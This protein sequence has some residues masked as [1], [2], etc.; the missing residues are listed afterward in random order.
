MLDVGFLAPERR[1]QGNGRRREA[2]VLA[3]EEGAQEVAVAVGGDRHPVSR[4]EAQRQQTAGQRARLIAQQ[5]IG[6][7]FDQFAAQGMEVD[8]RRLIRRIVQGLGYGGEVP[9]ADRPVGGGGRRGQD[10]RSTD[11]L[12]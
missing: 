9:L 5:G 2:G 10:W 11:G 6:E 1:R 4:R 3:G 12:F 7:H 8:P